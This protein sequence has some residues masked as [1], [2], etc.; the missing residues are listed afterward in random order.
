MKVVLLKDIKGTGRAN[1]AVDVKDG[2]AIN[3]LI[4]RKLAMPATK[5]SLKQAEFH[6]KKAEEART[7]AQSLI[8]HRLESLA[9]ERVVIKKKVNEKGHL[10]DGVDAK[11]LAELVHIP[12]EA[13]RLEKS[14]KEAGTFEV[15]VS[16]G[17]NFGKFTIVI[18]AE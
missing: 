14:I 6:I 11:E 15:P 5:A 7:I 18:E 10:Y 1:T 8:A 4:P 16:Y 12:A 3:F 9:D 17:E 13:I 2:H